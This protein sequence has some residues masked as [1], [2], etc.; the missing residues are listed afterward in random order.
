MRLAGW[1]EIRTGHYR[2][3]VAGIS[4]LQKTAFLQM[5]PDHAVLRTEAGYA[6]SGRK[7]GSGTRAKRVS[8]SVPDYCRPTQSRP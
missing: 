6:V 8:K 1:R 3:L 5:R 2:W 4:Q 7:D